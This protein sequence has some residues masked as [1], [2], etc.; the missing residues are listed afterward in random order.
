MELRQRQS[1]FI[2]KSG[3]VM[4][5]LKKPQLVKFS[6]D[7]YGIRRRKYGL[8]WPKWE[9]FDF[10]CDNLWWSVEKAHGKYYEDCHVSFEIAKEV[11]C[12]TLP[13]RE[14]KGTPIDVECD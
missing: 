14:E 4:S 8:L 5:W 12:K 9:Y 7:T 1:I 10:T 3:E 2:Q 13:M 6:D 11:F